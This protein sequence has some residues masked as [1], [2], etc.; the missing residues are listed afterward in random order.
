MVDI[1][2]L[3]VCILAGFMLQYM[4]ETIPAIMESPKGEHDSMRS[5]RCPCSK[6]NAAVLSIRAAATQYTSEEFFPFNR[7]V[8]KELYFPTVGILH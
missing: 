2:R 5:F 3:A 7:A 8:M 6:R 1:N 4:C